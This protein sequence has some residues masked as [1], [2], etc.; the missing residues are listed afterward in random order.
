MIKDLIKGLKLGAKPA[1]W[2]NTL[3][4]VF[5]VYFLFK[6]HWILAFLVMGTYVNSLLMGILIIKYAESKGWL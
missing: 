1:L 2:I 4:G 6:V 3:V 5:P